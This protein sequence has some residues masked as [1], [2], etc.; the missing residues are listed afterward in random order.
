MNRSHAWPLVVLVVA[1]VLLRVVDHPW[2]LAPIGALSLF[3][4][5]YV[6][7]KTWAFAVPLAAML[8]SDVALGLKHHNTDLYT[9][10]PLQS[11]VYFC[12]AISVCLGFG[13]H[14]AWQSAETHSRNKISPEPAT[15]TKQGRM[16]FAARS[17]RSVLPVVGAT[18][19]GAIFFFLVTN[20]GDWLL[21]YE[22][23]WAGLWECFV[24]AIPFFRTALMGDALYVT[25][26]F[27]G[28]ELL[29]HRFPVFGDQGIEPAR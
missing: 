29:R 13:I 2:N 16:S 23:S 18:L 25:V 8:L 19:A 28:Y 6:R 5:A 4:G 12:Y 22:Q 11:L 17:L 20:F 24:R 7:R 27:G 10:H 21:W 3:V 15:A 14:K 1:A 9:F 26:L